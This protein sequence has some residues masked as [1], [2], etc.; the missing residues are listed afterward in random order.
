MLRY[1]RSRL[2]Y[3]FLFEFHFFCCAHIPK[4]SVQLSEE[5]TNMINSAQAA[6][7]AMLHQYMA[8]R[9][10]QVDHFMENTWILG[11]I[12]QGVKDTRVLELIENENDLSEKGKIM[13]EF[14]EDASNEIFNRRKSLVNTLDEMEDLQISWLNRQGR[15]I[16]N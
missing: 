16:S 11:F 1:Y 8:E 14:A 13:L 9:R 2:I 5:L 3:P 12:G 15:Q 7:L 4:E 10:Q 6:H